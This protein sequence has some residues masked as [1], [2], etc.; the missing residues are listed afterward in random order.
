MAGQD[1]E[2]PSPHVPEGVSLEG[3]GFTGPKTGAST[4]TSTRI[5]VEAAWIVEPRSNYQPPIKSG[6]GE[7]RCWISASSLRPQAGLP[8][9]WRA[10]NRAS[11]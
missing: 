7:M 5:K 1:P 2:D 10:T 8:R 6:F 3:V 9:C 4:L 11:A